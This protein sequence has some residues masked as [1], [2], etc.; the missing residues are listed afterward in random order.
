MA[1]SA[2]RIA[3]IK[4]ALTSTGKSVSAY[5]QKCGLRAPCRSRAWLRCA[6]RCFA[7][8]FA[9]GEAPEQE[10]TQR[11]QRG[12]A[13]AAL[14]HEDAIQS[15]LDELTTVA[16][17]RAASARAAASRARRGRAATQRARLG[18]AATQRAQRRRAPARAPAELTRVHLRLASRAPVRAQDLS[19]RSSGRNADDVHKITDGVRRVGA[20]VRAKIKQGLTCVSPQLMRLGA[21]WSTGR[22]AS[23]RQALEAAMSELKSAQGASVRGTQSEPRAAVGAALTALAPGRRAGGRGAA[24]QGRRAARRCGGVC[25]RDGAEEG[26]GA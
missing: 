5:S 8:R 25:A 18:P 15:F 12:E 10:Q 6:E 3:E 22:E 11:F 16:K 14:L 20:G 21:T 2:A 9:A 13:D 17:V 26:C 19:G 23:E 4:H 1:D 24:A 7:R